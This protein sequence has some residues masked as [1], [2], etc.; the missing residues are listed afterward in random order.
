MIGSSWDGEL[1]FEASDHCLKRD[2]AG[3]AFLFFSFLF[4]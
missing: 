1:E 2:V 3:R 4:F